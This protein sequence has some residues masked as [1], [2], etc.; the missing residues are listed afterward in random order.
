MAS[1]T[2]IATDE[3]QAVSELKSLRI[4]AEKSAQE[5][6]TELRKWQASLG[7]GHFKRAYLLAGWSHG[8]IGHY[9]YGGETEHQHVTVT[10]PSQQ[11]I[12]PPSQPQ[13]NAIQSGTPKALQPDRLCEL[14]NEGSVAQMSQVFLALMP[15]ESIRAVYEAELAKESEISLQ[16]E[17]LWKVLGPKIYQKE[18]V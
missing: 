13:Q 10:E 6:T 9:L 16:L 4:R 14:V 12:D 1:A 17:V 7:R 3:R 8:R 2:Q 5:I 18:S 11:V 15:Y